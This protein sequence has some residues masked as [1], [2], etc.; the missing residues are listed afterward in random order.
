MST[1]KTFLDD[2]GPI[3]WDDL[4]QAHAVTTRALRQLAADKPALRALVLG[5]EHAPALFDKCELHSLDD[6]IVIY[7]AMES[8]GFRIRLRLA[9]A[10]QDERPHTHRF[11]F[12]TLI[13][14]GMYQQCWY[15]AGQPLDEHVDVASIVPVCARHEPAGSA[16]T[17]HHD[18]IHSTMTPP[19]T[20]SLVM[21]GP[22]AKRRAIITHKESGRVWFR[23]GEKDEPRERREEV[24]MPLARYR[25]WCRR[26]EAYDLI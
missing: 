20:V 8:R 17:I 9:T 16:F 2:L 13:L 12:S 1:V 26:L 6:K 5:V 23:Y 25:Q 3:D 21:R 15:T 18:A 7:D 19:D 22:A 11:S 14:R 10:Y 24:K 4:E